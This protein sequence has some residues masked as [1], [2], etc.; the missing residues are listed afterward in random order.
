[1]PRYANRRT[2]AWDEGRMVM[3]E[4]AS[5]WICPAESPDSSVDRERG[6]ADD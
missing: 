3:D 1:M 6:A 4:G 2:Q 5:E